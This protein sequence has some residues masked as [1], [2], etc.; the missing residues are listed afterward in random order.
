MHRP[1]FYDKYVRRHGQNE[2]L[3]DRQSIVSDE[4]IMIFAMFAFSARFSK[5]AYFDGT[6]PTTRGEVFA[7]RA[8]VIKDPI[9]RTVEEP[10]LE[11]VKGCVLLSCHCLTAGQMST[12]AILTSVCVRLAYNLGLNDIDGDQI[13]EDGTVDENDLDDSEAWVCKEELRRVWWAISDLDTFVSTILCQPFGI[14]R[15][16]MRVLLP[17]SDFLWFERLPTKSSVLLLQPSQTWRS[18]KGS[19]HQSGRAWYLVSNHLSSCI[20]DAARLPSRTSSDQIDELESA[21]S[22]LKLALPANFQ[23]Q[24]LHIDATNFADSNWIISTLLMILA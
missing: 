8:A 7:E 16:N 11:F 24:D 2:R 10:S 6:D 1:L 19:P 13:N 9:I 21:L 5:A 18:L 22:C 12:G 3:V 17:V 14:E 20:A 23:L 4:S 15:R